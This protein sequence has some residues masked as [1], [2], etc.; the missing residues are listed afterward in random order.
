MAKR[1]LLAGLMLIIFTGCGIRIIR[2]EPPPPPILL[3]PVA[4][5]ALDANAAR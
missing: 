3:D 4:Q 1:F 2:P 5:G